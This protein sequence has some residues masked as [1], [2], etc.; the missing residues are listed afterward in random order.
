MT[1][2]IMSNQIK[3]KV[4]GDEVFS[5]SRHN[6]RTCQC[7][8]VSVDGGQV[9]L[10]RVGSRSDYEELSIS[11]EEELVDKMVQDI[12]ESIRTGRNSFGIACAV[13][14]TIRDSGY[15]LVE[16]DNGK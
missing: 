6:F 14:R 16:Y 9:Y 8:L 4:C 7:G 12:S 2:I 10:R 3:C 1:K 11:W 5:V 15:T 13:A